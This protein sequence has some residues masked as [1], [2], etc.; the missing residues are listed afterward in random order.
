[1]Q[2]SIL[3]VVFGVHFYHK[4]NL[5]KITLTYIENMIVIL[6]SYCVRYGVYLVILC[7]YMS[8]CMCMAII[9]LATR[10]ELASLTVS[11]YTCLK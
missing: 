7:M 6:F 11:F 3:T 10:S 5:T 1:M 9:L 4:N 8:L 2:P